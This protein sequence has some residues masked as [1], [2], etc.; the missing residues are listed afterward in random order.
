ML[1]TF[2]DVQIIKYALK[3]REHSSIVKIKC[4]YSEL[5]DTMP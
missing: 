3:E 5:V 2:E 1:I 4:V